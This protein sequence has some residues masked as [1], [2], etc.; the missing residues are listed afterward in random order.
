MKKLEFTLLHIPD[1][2]PDHCISIGRF[3]MGIL[4]EYGITDAEMERR[5]EYIKKL[6]QELKAANIGKLSGCQAV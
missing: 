2:S 3:L 5:K 1:P 6:N 4:S